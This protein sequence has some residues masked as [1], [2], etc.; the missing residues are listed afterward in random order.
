MPKGVKRDLNKDR[1]KK[2]R[3]S[4]SKDVELFKMYGAQPVPP[5]KGLDD[6]N[7][8]LEW[9]HASNWASNDEAVPVKVAV[10]ELVHWMKE[11]GYSKTDVD[12]VK[13]V[14][15][16]EITSPGRTAF[17]LNNNWPASDDT[18]NWLKGKIAQAIENGSALVKSN[19]SKKKETD[20]Q[21]ILKKENKVSPEI[22]N[23]HDA[24]EIT[25]EIE[26]GL[27]VSEKG[28][29]SE[30]IKAIT[31]GKKLVVLKIALEK[32]KSL[33]DELSLFG[34]DDQ[35][36]EA[37]SFM[38]KRQVNRAIKGFDE[39][40]AI[41]EGQKINKSTIRKPRS[42]KPKSAAIQIKRV[43]FKERDQENNIVSV[44]P[45]DVVGSTKMVVWN[46]KYRKIG[47]Y[48]SKDATGFSFKGTTLQNFADGSEQKTLRG[49]K[50]S[51]VADKLLSF[52]K[53][54]V[55][56][57]DGLF[58]ELKTTNTKLNGRFG[59]ETVILKVYK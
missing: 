59:P 54:T 57:V 20:K 45:I 22:L 2:R 58:A 43:K 41:L 4:I 55:R 1:K 15:E 16:Y 34:V 56:K 24:Q 7:F 23:R 19:K 37:Y 50:D 39:A 32:I 26:E 47:I 46:P 27:I 5:K 6:P 14:P 38:G 52:R 33:K 9:I 51:S 3:A 8:R 36:T 30:R 42:K 11:N 31:K 25:D 48:Y 53:A 18:S 28:I 10:K 40:T 12:A 21:E 29:S 17:L 13:A 49:T 44:Q 35:V